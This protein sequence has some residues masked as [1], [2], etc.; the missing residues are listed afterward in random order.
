MLIV[1][2]PV[3]TYAVFFTQLSTVDGPQTGLAYFPIY[4][5]LLEVDI[6]AIGT[7]GG[8]FLAL[9]VVYCIFFALACVEGGGI[10]KAITSSTREGIAALMRNPM[11]GMIVVMGATLLATEILQFFQSAAGV[12]TGGLS[13]DPFILLMNLTLAPLIEEVGYRFFLFG[14]PL[15]LVLLVTRPSAKKFLLTMWRPSAAW[16]E[17]KP[18]D[19]LAPPTYPLKSF[20]Y[21]L[22]ALSS[23]L[24]G[25]AHYLS[26]AGWDVGKVSEA[27]L[28]GVALAYV[29][30]RYGLHASILF[31]WVVDYASNAYAFLGQG[32]YG[33]SWTANSVYSLVPAVDIIFLVGIPGLVYIL[34]VIV[35]RLN[36][37]QQV[38]SADDSSRQINPD[39]PGGEVPGHISN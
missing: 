18:V 30:M 19:E 32:L 11:T 13:G 29:Y 28:D 22:I 31:H 26:G 12:Q 4:I 14:L 37:T 21:F 20:A 10:W 24:F 15:A 9:T 5:G 34:S 3:G 39:G 27:A 33:V 6:P 35:K 17:G 25:L 38:P 8:L 23:I 1:S 36:K 16:D 2:V 7:L